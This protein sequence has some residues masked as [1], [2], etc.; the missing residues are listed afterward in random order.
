MRTYRLI[1]FSSLNFWLFQFLITMA[2][3]STAKSW[4]HCFRRETFQNSVQA[5]IFAPGL[6]KWTKV[7]QAWILV[8][9]GRSYTPEQDE[10]NCVRVNM[11]KK[12]H[13]YSWIVNVQ[14]ESG[15]DHLRRE[16]ETVCCVLLTIK[17]S[18]LEGPII[19]LLSGTFLK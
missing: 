18:D 14:Q 3:K 1:D 19:F 15:R 11:C 9:N 8:K 4:F 7:V 5:R 12:T 6:K 16:R 17:P 10:A 13:W 2:I